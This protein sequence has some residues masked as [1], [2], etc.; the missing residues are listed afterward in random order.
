M[1][2]GMCGLCH[3]V[4][5]RI[6]P[7]C[8]TLGRPSG[9]WA[10]HGREPR[11]P[12][13]HRARRLLAAPKVP[14]ALGRNGRRAVTFDLLRHVT[15]RNVPPAARHARKC[16][17]GTDVRA[18]RSHFVRSSSAAPGVETRKP[19]RSGAFC[20]GPGWIRTATDGLQIRTSPDRGARAS[21]WQGGQ[22]YGPS[23]KPLPARKA[24]CAPSTP[25]QGGGGGSVPRAVDFLF[26]RPPHRLALTKSPSGVPVAH[27]FHRT[28]GPTPA[29]QRL[30]GPG[31]AGGGSL[32]ALGHRPLFG[33]RRCVDA[34]WDGGADA[35]RVLADG[36]AFVALGVGAGL[37]RAAVEAA[38]EAGVAGVVGVEVEGRVGCL[39][40]GQGRW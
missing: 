29:A 19:R 24:E 32:L 30:R 35:E 38:L 15:T 22:G 11:L 27:R 14:D 21:S 4:S 8:R 39:A 13:L 1:R 28:E 17:C 34:A 7:P 6:S 33:G 5:A 10:T 23:P 40:A 18:A 26:L 12:E 25:P 36:Q 3:E 37:E 16:R 31:R 2:F 20:G 9:I